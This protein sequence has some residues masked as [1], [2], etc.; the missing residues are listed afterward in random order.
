MSISLKITN[1]KCFGDEPAGFD[2]IRP[3]NIIAG[4]NNSG[5]S[6][7]LD[8]VALACNATQI[9][10]EFQRKEG[11]PL[12]M[13]TKELTE[14]DLKKG[15]LESTSGGSIGANHWSY[16]SRFVGTKMTVKLSDGTSSFMS[17]DLCGKDLNKKKGAEQFNTVARTLN[18][19]FA[20]KTFIPL[21]ADRNIVLENDKKDLSIDENGSGLTN[22]IQQY[23]NRS[24]LDTSLIEYTFLSELNKI[25]A[26]ETR[27]DAIR[28]QKRPSGLWEVYL[29]E[30]KKGRGD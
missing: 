12:V 26:P 13:M 30:T 28:V 9:E 22:T 2:G 20:K 29:G 6:A 15:F 1:Y 25:F 7:L 27:F 17:L 4:K 14:T 3:I 5:K 10:E 16:G 11:S 23:I 24:E 8:L 18:H 21:R 19:T